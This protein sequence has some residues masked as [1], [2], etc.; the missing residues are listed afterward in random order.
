MDSSPSQQVVKGPLVAGL[1]QSARVRVVESQ[2]VKPPGRINPLDFLGT[3]LQA[4]GCFGKPG[5][6]ELYAKG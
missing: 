4:L 2:L 5:W 6:S 3:S 1:G